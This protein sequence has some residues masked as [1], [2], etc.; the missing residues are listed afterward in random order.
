MA[1]KRS[2]AVTRR[3]GVAGAITRWNTAKAAWKHAERDAENYHRDHVERAAARLEQAQAPQQLRLEEDEP[4]VR[5]QRERGALESY[6]AA[7]SHFNELTKAERAAV[8]WLLKTPAPTREAM[9]EKIQILI[10]MVERD[11]VN[12][13]DLAV[14][15]RSLRADLIDFR[16]RKGT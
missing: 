15:L 2:G 8:L 6:Q 1:H 10:D 3:S 9:A 14:P 5:A 12:Q 16:A 4:T 13:D 11:I 7:E